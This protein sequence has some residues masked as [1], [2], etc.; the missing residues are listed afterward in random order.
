MISAFYY[1]AVIGWGNV[2][3]Q[4]VGVADIYD[5]LDLAFMVGGHERAKTWKLAVTAMQN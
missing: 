5:N 2:V 1:Y 4:W 3:E